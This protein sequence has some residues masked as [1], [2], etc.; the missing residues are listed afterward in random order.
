MQSK[1]PAKAGAAILMVGSL[2]CLHRTD[3]LYLAHL[4]TI[5]RIDPGNFGDYPHNA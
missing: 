3:S 4:N 5:K 1:M 2:L